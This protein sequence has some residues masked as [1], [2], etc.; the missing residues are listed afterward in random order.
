MKK[1]IFSTL[2]I[3]VVLV[4]LASISSAQGSG[5]GPPNCPIPVCNPIPLG[6][7]WEVVSSCTIEPGFGGEAYS[8]QVYAR[9]LP[10]GGR[11]LCRFPLCVPAGT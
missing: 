11:E 8:C 7:E 2:L 1:L 4:S 6:P 5:D 10:T 3:G 9:G